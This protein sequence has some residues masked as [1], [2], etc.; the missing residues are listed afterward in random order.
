MATTIRG[1]L[2]DDVLLA[3]GLD[4]ALIGTAYFEG[5][6]VA[7]Y[8]TTKVISALMLSNK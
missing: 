5:V 4:N 1:L 7:V 6:E 2:N 8:S 3:Y